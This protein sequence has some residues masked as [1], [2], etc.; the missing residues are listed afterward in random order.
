MHIIL[1][2]GFRFWLMLEICFHFSTSYIYY[3]R[4]YVIVI[5]VAE[6][7]FSFSHLVHVRLDSDMY[8]VIYIL[9]ILQERYKIITKG[10]CG[11]IIKRAL[12]IS[13]TQH[14]N[15]L[16]IIFC[17]L[18][19]SFSIFTHF[20]KNTKVCFMDSQLLSYVKGKSG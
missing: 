13:C 19:L 18:S 8:L 11:S 2:L 14:M 5:W 12:G 17:L 3:G 16:L 4:Y 6:I 10:P 20:N 7:Q 15:C 1:A 9:H